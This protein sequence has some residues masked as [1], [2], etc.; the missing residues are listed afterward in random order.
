ML[1]FMYLPAEWPNLT[2]RAS[3]PSFE[4]R[5]WNHIRYRT[6]VGNNMSNALAYKHS[7]METVVRGKHNY[8]NKVKHFKRSDYLG[9]WHKNTLS[10]IVNGTGYLRNQNSPVLFGTL[11][12]FTT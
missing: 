11:R 3:V 12:S 2:P 10:S 9:L 5:I 8:G 1:C 7:V 4:K 6:I